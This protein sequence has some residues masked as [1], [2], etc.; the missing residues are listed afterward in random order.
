[1]KASKSELVFFI[2]ALIFIVLAISYDYSDAGRGARSSLSD[3][4]FG[5]HTSEFRTHFDGS[6]T[7]GQ[8]RFLLYDV[9]NA[10]MERVFAGISNSGGSG[11]KLLRIDN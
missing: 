11:F 6:T 5:E 8:T 4:T 3:A 1:M 10:K 2:I 9:D 7:A